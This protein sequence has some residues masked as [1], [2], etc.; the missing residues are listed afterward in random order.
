MTDSDMRA[1]PLKSGSLLRAYSLHWL[2]LEV[3]ANYHYTVLPS[4]GY[5]FLES[6]TIS[7]LRV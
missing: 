4:T 1:E 7:T 3:T 6:H 5:A 2:G